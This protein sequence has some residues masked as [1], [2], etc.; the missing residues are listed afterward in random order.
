M[1]YA[2][3]RQDGKY[4]DKTGKKF[5]SIFVLKKV[6]SVFLH[7]KWQTRYLCKCDCGKEFLLEGGK[8]GHRKKKTCGCGNK[9]KNLVGQTFGSLTVIKKSDQQ[10]EGD[11]WHSSLWDCECVCGTVVRRSS[12]ILK[13]KSFSSCGCALSKPKYEDR[14]AFLWRK[15]YRVNIITA[16]KDRS[17]LPSDISFERFKE[18]VTQPCSYCG[19]PYDKVWDDVSNKNGKKI[20]DAQIKFIGLDRVD[21]GVPYFDYNV[22]PACDRCNTAKMA[23]S[24]YEWL[25]FIKTSYEH[26]YLNGGIDKLVKFG[27]NSEKHEV[28]MIFPDTRKPTR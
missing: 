13:S 3:N 9:R 16:Q 1:P 27:P 15:A 5:F 4:S 11:K 10:K 8:I 14:E 2:T 21:S 22:V 24:F 6:D 7:N 25:S 17:D 28:F 26:L 23:Q 19:K 18:L 20:S 12:S